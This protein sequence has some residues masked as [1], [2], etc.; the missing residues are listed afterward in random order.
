VGD[1]ADRPVRGRVRPLVYVDVV[2]STGTLTLFPRTVKETDVTP[3]TATPLTTNVPPV[4]G[5]SLAMLMVIG[6]VRLSG[7][8]QPP[9]ASLK[10]Q[11]SARVSVSQ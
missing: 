6:C 10:V 1:G 3:S 11:R 5:E 2:L 4:V 9:P 7:R 8:P